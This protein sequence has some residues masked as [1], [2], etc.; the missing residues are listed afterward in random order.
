MMYAVASFVGL[1][2]A[3]TIY[4]VAASAM[5]SYINENREPITNWVTDKCQK[6]KTKLKGLKNDYRP[7]RT[8]KNDDKL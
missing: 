8:T 7:N 3:Y 2:A 5:G 4:H 6:A 1:V